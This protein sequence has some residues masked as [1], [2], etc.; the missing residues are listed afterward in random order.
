MG[1]RNSTPSPLAGAAEHA[2]PPDS[3]PKDTASPRR[4]GDSYAA[5]AADM[6]DF[7]ILAF[8]RET[9]HLLEASEVGDTA[10]V[11]AILEEHPSCVNASME[12]RSA[13]DM[14][15][16]GGHTECVRVLL[17]HGAAGHGEETAGL[18]D[19]SCPDTTSQVL[20]RADDVGSLLHHPEAG[21]VALQ[22]AIAE[23]LRHIV[24]G[25]GNCR[26]V[27]GLLAM[28]AAVPGVPPLECH[29]AVEA[30]APTFPCSALQ[31][32]LDELLGIAAATAQTCSLELQLFLEAVR[33]GQ[34]PDSVSGAVVEELLDVA[35]FEYVEVSESLRRRLRASA[36]GRARRREV[37]VQLAF[38]RTEVAAS[39]A[40]LAQ[41]AAEHEQHAARIAVLLCELASAGEARGLISGYW[42]W[43]DGEAAARRSALAEAMELHRKCGREAA[44]W[45]AVLEALLD[46]AASDAGTL[47]AKLPCMAEVPQVRQQLRRLYEET[48]SALSKMC[49]NFAQPGAVQLEQLQIEDDG[50]TPVSI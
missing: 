48:Y 41:C 33:A 46:W 13:L 16:S 18:V 12:G 24:G 40:T 11:S 19:D 3:A 2:A 15:L 27:E 32:E 37:R 44:A 29:F 34:T 10:T 50:N 26:R 9:R 42:N 22:G 5:A 21:D 14:A 17:Q 43:H 20:D 23:A 8:P 30:P 6:G 36:G 1:A 7:A 28:A 49:E 35:E 4:R 25:V 38:M 45:T 47:A 31:P 39:H